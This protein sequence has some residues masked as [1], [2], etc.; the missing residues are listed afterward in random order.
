MYFSRTNERAHELKSN[1]Y[2]FV[3]LFFEC[4][5]FCGYSFCCGL[6]LLN[7][8]W[9]CMQ[10][11]LFFGI[12][13]IF[14]LCQC[15]SVCVFGSR[16]YCLLLLFL[17]LMCFLNALAGNKRGFR[18]PFID[19]SA[20]NIVLSVSVCVCVSACARLARK[21]WLSTIY[22]MLTFIVIVLKSKKTS[23]LLFFFQ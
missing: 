12:W 8:L 5:I 15:L 9:K 11:A 4:D 6:L 23:F 16:F 17:L 20:I 21:Q 10:Y 3:T 1:E 7:E 19:A 18:F 13:H 14:F 2:G 22:T